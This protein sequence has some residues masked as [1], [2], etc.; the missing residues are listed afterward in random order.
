MGL[1]VIQVK[2]NRVNE[3]EALLLEMRS[4]EFRVGSTSQ[5]SQERIQAL[6]ERNRILGDQARYFQEFYLAY[7]AKNIKHRSTQGGNSN[8]LNKSPYR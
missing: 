6:E 3:L 4:K 8:G 5:S 1:W 7:H 2:A